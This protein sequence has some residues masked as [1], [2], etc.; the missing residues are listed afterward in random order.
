MGKFTLD[1]ANVYFPNGFVMSVKVTFFKLAF[2]VCK[3]EQETSQ[4]CQ[5]TD[6]KCM[7][8]F[9]SNTTLTQDD[10]ESPNKGG[11]GWKNKCFP[12]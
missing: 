8:S 3:F 4:K 2:Y 12:I 7:S 9:H 6:G 5:T 11:R 1:L 10:D